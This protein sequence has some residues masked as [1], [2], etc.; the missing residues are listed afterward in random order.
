M[1]GIIVLLIAKGQA[2]GLTPGAFV[3]VMLV[4]QHRAELMVQGFFDLDTRHSLRKSVFVHHINTV[5][6]QTVST[7]CFRTPDDEIIEA[8]ET[9]EVLAD[10]GRGIALDFGFDNAH[11]VGKVVTV[12]GGDDFGACFR[13]PI[14][15]EPFRAIVGQ[16]YTGVN[17]NTVVLFSCA[18][19]RS[20]QNQR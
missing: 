18:R 6:S 7:T 15:V 5:L 2:R 1:Q 10:Q 19:S 13:L 8:I 17:G 3:K 9:S 11:K 20:S 12:C 14:L 4:H 16:R